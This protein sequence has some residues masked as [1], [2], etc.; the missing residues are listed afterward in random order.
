MSDTDLEIIDMDETDSTAVEKT[1]SAAT[2]AIELTQLYLKEIGFSPLLTAAEEQ[3]LSRQARQGDQNARHRLIESNLRLVVNIARHY[4]LSKMD[5][6]DLISEGNLGLMR[7]AEK[8]NPDLGYRFSTYATW[9]INHFIERAIVNQ[10]RTVRIPVHVAAKVQAYN[11]ATREL[12]QTLDHPPTTQE[13]ANFMNKSQEKV[14]RLSHVRQNIS[15]L[16]A[17]AYRQ[18]DD[19]VTL[20]EN[21]VDENNPDPATILH[22]THLRD[23]MHS[24][25]Q[26]LEETQREIIA[27]RFGLLGHDKMT[28]EAIGVALNISHEKARYVQINAIKKLREIIRDHA[29]KNIIIDDL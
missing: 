26:Q 4:L 2:P 10:G 12:A 9:W 11:R 14:A 21:L 28:F 22:E 19:S 29:G 18:D 3:S 13:I 5:F 15:S 8:F 16:D 24:W 6:L 25:L 7:A 17:P 27:R 1:K 23:L 20:G